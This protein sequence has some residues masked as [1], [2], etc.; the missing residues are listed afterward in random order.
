MSNYREGYRRTMKLAGL[1]EGSDGMSPGQVA[2]Y[3]LG[4]GLGGRILGGEIGEVVKEIR[5][6]GADARRDAVL[7]EVFNRDT[8]SSLAQRLRTI[9]SHPEF[10]SLRNH[11]RAVGIPLGIVGAGAGLYAGHQRNTGGDVTE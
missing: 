2:G 4:G 9:K 8:D 3:S 11:T 1:E 5:D 10:K 7:G 6:P